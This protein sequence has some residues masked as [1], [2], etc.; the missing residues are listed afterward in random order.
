M[1]SVE[2]RRRTH[3]AA[4]AWKPGLPEIGPSA[5]LQSRACAGMWG[6]GRPSPGYSVSS[7]TKLPCH[8][9]QQM[10][11]RRTGSFFFFVCFLRCRRCSAS[12]YA[13]AA[14]YFTDG[15]LKLP[16]LLNP[17]PHLSTHSWGMC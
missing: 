17:A 8:K 2:S 4:T 10:T 15:I 6:A 13:L 16:S 11:W 12:G 7:E 3:H 14:Q 5:E 9:V 1:E